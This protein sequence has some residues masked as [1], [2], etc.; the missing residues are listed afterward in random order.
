MEVVEGGG[1][2]GK[3]VFWTKEAKIRAV[4][5]QLNEQ[6]RLGDNW[7]FSHLHGLKKCRSSC[8]S[9]DSDAEDWGWALLISPY[10][11]HDSAAEGQ[12]PILARS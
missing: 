12:E 10:T 9:T 11:L 6:A 1:L 3:A 5:H 4:Q 2:G 7:C 8:L